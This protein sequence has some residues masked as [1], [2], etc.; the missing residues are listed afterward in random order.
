[1]D[2]A[3]IL[4]QIKLQIANVKEESFSR[5]EILERVEKWLTA[6]EEESWLEEYNRDDNR[7]N[8]GRD[9]HLTLKRAEKARNL[10][11]KMPGMVEALA[12]KTMTW[13]IERD[14]EFLYDGICLLSMLEEYT[15]LRQEKQEERR[16]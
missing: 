12:S 15:I 11:N 7:Y 6:C 8:A 4:E 1:M 10:V 3:S 13:E 5:K 14:T 16:S 9:A 2:P